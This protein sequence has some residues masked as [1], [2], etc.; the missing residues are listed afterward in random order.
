M[1]VVA[2][3]PLSPCHTGIPSSQCP[4]QL[5]LAGS[6]SQHG[7]AWNC[8][9]LGAAPGRQAMGLAQL[10]DQADLSCLCQLCLR[11]ETCD[12]GQTPRTQGGGL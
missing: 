1:E 4:G 12:L 6:P 3:S 5:V 8:A 9:H 7:T 2:L 10:Q 11:E